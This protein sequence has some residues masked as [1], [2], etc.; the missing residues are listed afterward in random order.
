[1]WEEEKTAAVERGG[2]ESGRK[3]RSSNE[4]GVLLNVPSREGEGE[5]ESRVTN[6]DVGRAR[7]DEEG[8]REGGRVR[9]V[10]GGLEVKACVGLARLWAKPNRPTLTIAAPTRTGE[11][12]WSRR[13]G[14]M[15]EQTRNSDATVQPD[16]VKAKWGPA[17]CRDAVLCSGV[18]HHRHA[19]T[20]GNASRG[21]H[22]PA[23]AARPD[24]RTRAARTGAPAAR[25][26]AD[27]CG[28]REGD[29]E[30][31]RGRQ[32]DRHG[33]RRHRRTTLPTRP[34]ATELDAE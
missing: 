25:L 15:Q 30:T 16:E 23:I 5:R 9:F 31:E 28:G 33:E 19:A 29:R 14:K 1:V 18:S 32:R 3:D 7:E 27:V 10:P 21:V 26:V 22:L 12:V 6:K 8:G 13:R 2:M 4:C 24:M 20:I 11:D 34:A 17:G